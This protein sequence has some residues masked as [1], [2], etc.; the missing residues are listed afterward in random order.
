MDR[1]VVASIGFG[2][3]VG[4]EVSRGV[5]W[6]VGWGVIVGEIVQLH[7]VKII[8]IGLRL[9]RSNDLNVGVGFNFVVCVG[10]A[11]ESVGS[12]GT[13]ISDVPGVTWIDNNEPC[14]GRD[15]LVDAESVGVGD[16]HKF[17]S[18]VRFGVS[19][20]WAGFG[21]TRDGFGLDWD[22]FVMV[23]GGF[24]KIRDGI[25]LIWRG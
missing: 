2:R 18:K 8:F 15:F 24:G 1:Y 12:G 3:G 17:L 10:A 19:L 7:V 21:Q 6:R 5:G 22:G 11:V 20:A 23:S 16:G 9:G 13:P 25:E 14:V 4:R